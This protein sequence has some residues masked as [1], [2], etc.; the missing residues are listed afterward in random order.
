MVSCDF[1]SHVQSARHNETYRILRNLM[2]QAAR[3][4]EIG[5]DTITTRECLEGG[6]VSKLPLRA[7][8]EQGRSK[9]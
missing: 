6:A 9:S 2:D 4:S 1:R 5:F 3:P 7:Y 8:V